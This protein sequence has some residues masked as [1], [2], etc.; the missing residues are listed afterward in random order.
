MEF[1][2]SDTD[3]DVM[4]IK[5]DGGLNSDN[6]DQFVNK[7]VALI[8]AG[9]SKIVVDCSHLD[10]IASYG[11]G[12]LVRLHSKLAKIGGDVKLACVK[13]LIEQVFKITHLNRIFEMYPDV[14]RACLMFRP[15]DTE[16]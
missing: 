12:V 7:L 6:A 5:A 14:S 10:T 15:K 16:I 11:L 13:G 4:I 1:Y 9:Q 8:D 3:K 2:Y